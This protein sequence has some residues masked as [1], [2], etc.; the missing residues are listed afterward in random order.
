MTVYRLSL[1]S[2]VQ[3]LSGTGSL[4]YGGRWNSQGV[5]VVYT[6]ESAALALLETLVNLSDE[7]IPNDFHLVRIELPDDAKV[8]TITINQ[9]SPDWRN[10]PSPLNLKKFGDDFAMEGESLSL[11]VPSAIV[12]QE[13]N[14]I[15]NPAHSQ[16]RDV[17]ILSVEPFHFDARLLHKI[18]SP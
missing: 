6:S 15:I 9:L 3:D 1:Q 7:K 18:N 16:M 14:Y 12:P 2:F 8:Q 13:S 10:F 11:R 4:I 5:P 17:K